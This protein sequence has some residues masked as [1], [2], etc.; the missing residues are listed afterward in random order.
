MGSFLDADLLFDPTPVH[1]RTANFPL[2]STKLVEIADLTIFGASVVGFGGF[3]RTNFSKKPLLMPPLLPAG[4][5][6]L[7]SR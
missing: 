4:R 6:R 1:K 3:A 7:G 2:E 5:Q